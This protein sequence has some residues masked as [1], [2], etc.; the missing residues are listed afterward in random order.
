MIIAKTVIDNN[1][2]LKLSSLLFNFEE[3]LV[4]KNLMIILKLI[5]SIKSIGFYSYLSN[6][7]I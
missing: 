4:S 6:I 5:H 2:Q 7:Q 1:Y 3:I